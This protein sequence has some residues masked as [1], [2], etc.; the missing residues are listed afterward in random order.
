MIARWLNEQWKIRN[1][2][3]YPSFHRFNSTLN[4]GNSKQLNKQGFRS[5]LN[6]KYKSALNNISPPKNKRSLTQKDIESINKSFLKRTKGLE[7]IVTIKQLN[8][9]KKEFRERSFERY[10]KPSNEWLHN[11][12][13]NVSS[14]TIPSNYQFCFNTLWNRPLQIGDLVLL[15]SQPHELSMCV[16]LPY[17]VTDPRY[18]FVTTKGTILFY[19]RNQIQLRIPFKLPGNINSIIQKELNHGYD[20]IGTNRDKIGS[21]V[22]L[23][24]MAREKLTSVPTSKITKD[25]WLILPI[26]IK[27]LKLLN[28]LLQKDERP[29]Q[30][31][32]PYLVNLIEKLDLNKIKD[33]NYL[34]TLTTNIDN[35]LNASTFLATYWGIKEQQTY[36]MWGDIHINSAI[37]SPISVT[38]FPMES[39]QHF[40]DKLLQKFSDNNYE[41]LDNFVKLVKTNQYERISR[42]FPE[43]IRL[44]KDYS[45][46]NFVKNIKNNPIIT[47]ISTLFRKLPKYQNKDITKDAC[48]ELLEEISP[49]CKFVNPFLNNFHLKSHIDNSGPIF[50]LFKCD[51]NEEFFEVP[52]QFSQVYRE[53]NSK[54]VDYT[55]LPV[56]C[57]D[58]ELAHEIDDGVSII[59]RTQCLSTIFV[60]I[61]DPISVFPESIIGDHISSPLLKIALD[62][63]FTTYLPDIVDPMLPKSVTQLTGMGT[64]GKKTRAITFSVDVTFTGENELKILY[65]T[66]KIQLSYVSNFPKVTYDTV[67]KILS[68][69]KSVSVSTS[70]KKDL[71]RMA[72][73]ARE[74]RKNRISN[75]N[76]ILFGE[77]FN[78][79]LVQLQIFHDEMPHITFKDQVDSPSTILVSEFM[80]LANTFTGSF[81]KQNS[82]PGV[83]RTYNNLPLGP[84]AYKS[85]AKLQEQTK[86]GHIPDIFDVVKISSLLNS[87]IYSSTPLPHRM[88]GASSY[89]T[90]TSPL[91]RMPDLINHIQI[92]RYLSDLDLAFQKKD[93]DCMLWKIQSRADI[94][95]SLA[96]NV[97]SYWTLKYLKDEVGKNSN[98]TFEVLI[99]SYPFDG[100]VHCTFPDMS[101]AR[102]TLKIP[103]NAPHPK[104]GT[105]VKNCRIVNIDCLENN[106]ELEIE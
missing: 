15:K 95:K 45:G 51:G 17:S 47:I 50:D 106:L 30:I 48:F 100:K 53:I 101:F 90:V 65:N 37:L 72:V 92:H 88:I 98:R 8:E 75:G 24:F 44:L 69:D 78:K 23:P 74:L 87:S 27:K 71:E 25:A 1:P 79:G 94:I 21:T 61:A 52:S 55:E 96:N 93:I 66:F 3:G 99:T 58:S 67:D 2:I 32:F 12:A 18:T 62:K 105:L 42:E 64:P 60:H 5:S 6:S 20:S 38:I 103:T 22:I 41:Y 59:Q 19:P 33:V 36:N 35:N 9:I 85:Y 97:S 63:G 89:L 34:Q 10:L 7:P 80:I 84:M 29:Y 104:I 39:R 82:I 49:K 83:F 43:I 16:G 68:N 4:V 11:Q 76:A 91:R 77:G 13:K 86:R 81:F 54:R 70:M 57:I 56:Y 31:P 40:Y 73:I 28:R 14:W 46:G 102:G 26:V